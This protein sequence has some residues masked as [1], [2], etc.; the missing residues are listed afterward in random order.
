[1]RS[2]IECK[3]D[4]WKRNSMKKMIASLLSISFSLFL[5]LYFFLSISFFLIRSLCLPPS[6]S[7]CFTPVFSSPLFSFLYWFIHDTIFGS[8]SLPIYVRYN[9]LTSISSWLAVKRI[10]PKFA[11]IRFIRITRTP[12]P[13]VSW[14]VHTDIAIQT[15]SIGDLRVKERECKREKK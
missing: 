5:S 11:R 1:M 10:I 7:N 13:C 2:K 14:S 3:E 4:K 9:P 12:T 6:P 15:P 8:L